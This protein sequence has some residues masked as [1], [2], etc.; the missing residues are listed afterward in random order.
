MANVSKYNC[1]N[2][3]CC[4]SVCGHYDFLYHSTAM[5]IRR[6]IWKFRKGIGRANS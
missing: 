5:V 2:L 4:N 3:N 1:S 6:W